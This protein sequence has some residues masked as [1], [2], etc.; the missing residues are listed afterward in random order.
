MKVNLTQEL[1]KNT[2][3][4]HVVVSCLTDTVA[5]EK[6]AENRTKDGLICEIKLTINGHELDLQSFAE[7][8]Q[9]QVSRMIKDRAMEIVKEKFDD[10]GEILYDLEERLKPEIEKRLEDWEREIDN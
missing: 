7:H 4:S 5:R 2:L 1:R 10:V 6:I 3:L 9:S 8:W